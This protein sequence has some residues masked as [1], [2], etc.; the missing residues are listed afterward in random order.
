MKMMT[1]VKTNI[2]NTKAVAF[3]N[4][5]QH[6]QVLTNASEGTGV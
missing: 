5:T 4:A 6:G 3:I 2:K 1:F